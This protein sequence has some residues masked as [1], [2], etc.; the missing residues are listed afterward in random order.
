MRD[1]TFGGGDGLIANS[2][3]S[4]FSSIVNRLLQPDGKLVVVGA[5]IANFALF[6]FT[7]DCIVPQPVVAGV[8]FQD[9]DGNG[10]R[11]A[12]EAG[13]AGWE[14]REYADLDVDGLLDA[15]D[16]A[17]GIKGIYDHR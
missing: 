2:G 1:A 17:A 9:V 3:Y 16:L 13:L 4:G 15:A 7:G 11:D 5:G 12:G 8:K 6:R 14:I 10:N